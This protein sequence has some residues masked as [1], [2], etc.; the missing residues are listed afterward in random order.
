MS[1]IL[2]N[3]L[4]SEVKHDAAECSREEHDAWLTESPTADEV[5]EA[6][7][8]PLLQE[9]DCSAGPPE[10]SCNEERGNIDISAQSPAGRPDLLNYSIEGIIQNLTCKFHSLY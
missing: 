9:C 5:R 2:E 1:T 4:Q 6:E 7:A 3:V 8:K 10:L